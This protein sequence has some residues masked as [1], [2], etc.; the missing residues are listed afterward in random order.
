MSKKNEDTAN[1][2]SKSEVKSQVD[3]TKSKHGKKY[4]KVHKDLQNEL[5]KS[6]SQSMTLEDAVSFLIANKYVKFADTLEVH[7]NTLEQGL[8]GEA[9]LPHST[10][11]IAKVAVVDDSVLENLE[12]GIIDFDILVATPSMMPK[13]TKYAKIL[14]PRGLMPNPKSGTVGVNTAEIVKRFSGNVIRYKTEPKA[15]IIHL[16]VGKTKMGQELLVQNCQ[17]IIKAVDK[18]NIKSIYISSTMSPSVQVKI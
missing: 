9:D 2:D 1:S 5:K 18:K 4:N 10:G 3:V 12:K 13:L 6:S 7:I 17:A 14:G 15:A 16:V 8:K 11:K